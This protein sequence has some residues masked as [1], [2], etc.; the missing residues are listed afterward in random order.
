MAS[1]IANESTARLFDMAAEL[2]EQLEE[3]PND[4]KLKAQYERI[5][6]RARKA[7]SELFQERNAHRLAK[8][9]FAVSDEH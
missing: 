3:R 8:A 6:A 4:R 1:S 9:G 7:R 2:A 5:S